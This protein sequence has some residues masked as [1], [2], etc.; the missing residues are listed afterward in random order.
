MKNDT[1]KL[2]LQQLK[3]GD[4]AAYESLFKKYY[5]L[6]NV[7]AY[8]L[9]EDRMEAEDQVQLLFIELWNK[10]VHLNIQTSLKGYLRK[11]I[12]NRCL[13]TIEKWKLEE[14]RFNNRFDVNSD[15]T[16]PDW[17]ER[18]EM[19]NEFNSLLETLPPQRLQAF[20]LVYMDKKR[21]KDAAEE[22][23]ITINS[24]K[25]HLKLAVKDLRRKFINYK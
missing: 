8:L 25:T 21:Y 17:M 3:Q 5:K 14:K 11:A 20:Y 22:M 10:K 6:L 24:I 18:I 15:R 2:L 12:R 9:L 23:G 7:E 1:D 4:I 19:E 13:N 16:E